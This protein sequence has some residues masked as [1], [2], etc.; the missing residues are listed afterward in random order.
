[1]NYWVDQKPGNP[2]DQGSD[3]IR[4]FLDLKKN[5]KH[6]PSAT[7]QR[8]GEVRCS[9]LCSVRAAVSHDRKFLIGHCLGSR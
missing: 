5:Q 6:R 4:S 7:K 1:M 2:K 9:P 8:K 3:G